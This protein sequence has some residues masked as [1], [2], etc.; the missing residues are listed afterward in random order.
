MT[1]PH[2]RTRAVLELAKEVQLLAPYMHGKGATVRI[3]RESLTRLHGW[4]RHYPSPCEITMT[5]DKCPDLWAPADKHG[6][7]HG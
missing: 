2:E 6:V 5:A 7:S 1:V 3:P 4:L